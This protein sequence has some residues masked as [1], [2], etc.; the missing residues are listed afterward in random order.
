MKLTQARNSTGMDDISLKHVPTPRALSA[1]LEELQSKIAETEK[2]TVG[3]IVEALHERGIGVL[4]LFFAVPMA[5][6]IPVPPGINIL[7]ATPLVLLTFQQAIGGHTIWLPERITKR[8]IA[9]DK[10]IS[11]IESLEP[12]IQRLEKIIKPRLGWITYDGPSRFFGFLAVIM[13]L[14]VMI[15]LP[16]TNTAPSFG[17]SLMAI[18]VI[19]RDGLAVMAGAFIGMAWIT[20]LVIGIVIFG[21]GAFEAISGYLSSL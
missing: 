15:P 20:F 3:T 9:R 17:I 14:T 1:L 7:L 21:G 13:A 12:W 11:L 8:S 10:L 6:P 4:V 2:V 18:G 19:M 5:L 16:M